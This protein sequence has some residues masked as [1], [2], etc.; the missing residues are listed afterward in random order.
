LAQEEAF[1]VLGASEYVQ[2]HHQ[3]L[4]SSHGLVPTKS[5]LRCCAGEFEHHSP[6]SAPPNAQ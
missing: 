2:G 3:I 6:R 1:V 4:G 5:Q